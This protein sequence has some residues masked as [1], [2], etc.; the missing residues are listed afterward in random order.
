MGS[1]LD[2]QMRV[3]PSKI[4]N[5][6]MRAHHYSH[7]IVKQGYVHFGFF[8]HGHL[9]G[10]MSFGDPLDRSKV[11]PLVEGSPYNSVIEL[12]RMAFDDTMP[13][14]SESHGISMALK[15]LRRKAPQIKW[16]ISF[17]DACQCGDG[18]I[19]RAANFLLT[20][21]KKNENILMLPNGEILHKMK[22]ESHPTTPRKELGG[23]CY[24]DVT[25]GK[26]NINTYIEYTGAKRLT[27]YQ[28]RYIYFLDKRWRKRLTVPVLD[29]D[30]IDKLGAGMYKGERITRAERRKNA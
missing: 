27:G 19:Y 21:I 9:H 13:R 28:L 3:I 18:T 5:P 16:I 12:N 30:E 8:L 4:A 1:A 17:A 10:A 25:H 6:W 14:N 2:I 15:A 26:Y 24:F 23:K 29:Y 11:L 22:L 7:T 20:G